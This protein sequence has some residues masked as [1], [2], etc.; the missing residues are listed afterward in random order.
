[1]KL[2]SMRVLLT[3]A[4]GG[5]GR[6]IAR[7]LAAAGAHVLLVDRDARALDQVVKELA[8]A[9]DRVAAH[10]ADLT[11]PAARA[12]LCDAARGW[13]GGINVLVNNAGLNPF[14]LFEDLAPEQ[15][16]LTL[17]VNLQAP[18]HLC[19]D[20]LPQL[21]AREAATI[22]NVGSVFGA[23]GFPGYVAYSATKFAIRGFTEA[24]RRELADS[25]VAV[26]YL[27]PRATRT[28][29]NTAAVEEM[30]S[31][32]KVSMDPP[33]RVARELVRLLLRRRHSVVVGWPECVF[34]RINA[35]LPGI[36]DRSIRRQL[37]TIQQ[38]ARRLR[39]PRQPS[40][41]SAP[42]SNQMGSSTV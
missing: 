17:A 7:Q 29:I 4:A 20:L 41:G 25:G 22:V 31:R 5:I 36:V 28:T 33:E 11:S 23:I 39:V 24:L 27:A 15:I 18:M 12:Q 16:D 32:L 37:S 21:R 8:F 30:N 42:V 35:L 10:V 26:K 1:M 14:A 34:V 9:D 19:R 38:F 2:R 3:G 13:H 40:A 6:V